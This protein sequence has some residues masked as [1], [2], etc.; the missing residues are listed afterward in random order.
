MTTPETSLATWIELA[1]R[2]VPDRVAIHVDGAELTYSELAAAIEHLAR[3]LRANG[4]KKGDRVAVLLPNCPEWLSIALACAR[5]EL[6][7]VPVNTWY[8]LRELEFVLTQSGARALITQ[9]GFLAQNYA[10]MLSTIRDMTGG[11]GETGIASIDLLIS[12]DDQLPGAISLS[13]L[14]EQGRD[15]PALEEPSTDVPYVISYTS[16]TTSFPKGALLTQDGLAT[17]ARAFAVRLGVEEGASTYCAVP[18][19]HVAGFSFAALAALSHR[20]TVVANARF[21]GAE[22]WSAI[23]Q[24][25][26]RHVGGFEAI[27]HTLI[28]SRPD[29]AGASLKS[30]WWGGGPPAFFAEVEDSLG[31]RLMNL[32]GLTEASGN[33]TSTPLE[34]N[35]A[36]RCESEGIGLA[37]ATVDIVDD[38]GH[39]LEARAVGE[40]RVHSE[41]VMLGYHN[42]EDATAKAID[43]KGRLLTGDLGML[44]ERGRLHYVGRSKDMIKVGGENVSPSEI[45]AVIS[46][47][48]EVSEVAVVGMPDPRYGEVPVAFVRFLSEPVPQTELI[49]R[50]RTQ[51]ASFKMP[52]RVIEISEFPRTSTGKVLKTRLREQAVPDAHSAG[53]PDLQ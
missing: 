23:E 40:I 36:D 34:W 21:T 25:A 14:D 12:M 47:M 26:C 31:A 52:H 16:G 29:N 49:A 43:S 51:I 28:E 6:V 48:V 53:A 50:L 30:A 41:T 46:E 18:F 9:S 1:A 39:P 38:A 4:L 8:K 15:L 2:D 42:D 7:L 32:Y 19:F 24:F 5:A 27:F 20:G 17:N 11:A 37:G 10:E 3:S 13:A 45:E 35:V 44:D 33:V 22:A